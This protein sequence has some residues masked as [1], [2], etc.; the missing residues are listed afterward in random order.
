MSSRFKSGIIT[1]CSL[2]IAVAVVLWCGHDPDP[3]FYAHLSLI[4][5]MSVGLS[6]LIN[7]IVTPEEQDR[8]FN[9][10]MER[11]VDDLALDRIKRRRR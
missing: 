6:F 4:I 8:R 10:T 1:F 2:T 9:E 7:T 11:L 3:P 5:S